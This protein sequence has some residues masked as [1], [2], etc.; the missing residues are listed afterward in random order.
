[1]F[2]AGF[3]GR[4]FSEQHQDVIKNEENARQPFSAA[5]NDIHLR[6]LTMAHKHRSETN[7][8]EYN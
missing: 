7:G 3:I 1:M 6:A 8:E 5:L 4:L 2:R